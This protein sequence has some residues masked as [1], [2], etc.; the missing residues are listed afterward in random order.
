MTAPKIIHFLWLK[1]DTR[2]DGVLDKGLTFFKNRIIEL[3]PEYI[4]NFVYEWNKCLS[5]IDEYPEFMW[6]KDV[7]SNPNILLFHEEE[8][9]I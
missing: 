2:S 5:S 3:H 4:I 8:V 7:I 1:F 9:N 6:I